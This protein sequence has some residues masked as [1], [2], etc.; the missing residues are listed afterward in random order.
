MGTQEKAY[1]SW[2]EL[3]EENAYLIAHLFV[4]VEMRGK[5]LGRKLLQEAIEEMRA[6]GKYK[7]I[8]LS[9]DSSNEDPENPIELADLVEFYESE[10]FDLEYA[11]AIVT[12][13]MS[14]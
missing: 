6:D 2:E 12:M 5:G 3:E 9:A 11:G 8:K 4:P 10:G 7:E 13:S 1:C 14:I